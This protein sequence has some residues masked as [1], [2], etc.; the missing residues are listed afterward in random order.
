MQALEQCRVQLL[1]QVADLAADGG[2]T[3]VQFFRGTTETAVTAGRFERHQCVDR[4]QPAVELSYDVK[5]SQAQGYV[6]FTD[7]PCRDHDG[8]STDDG[9][10][11]H[12]GNRRDPIHAGD[13][14]CLDIDVVGAYGY[15]TDFSRTFLAGDGEVSAHQRE[16]YRLAHEE[17][18]YNTGLIRPGI[19]FRQLADSAW[20]IPDRYYP[21]CYFVMMHGCGMTGEYPYTLHARDFDGAYDGVVEENMALCVESCIGEPNGREGMKLENEYLVTADGVENLTP[22]PVDNRP[23]GAAEQAPPGTVAPAVPGRE[24]TEEEPWQR[25]GGRSSIGSRRC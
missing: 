2:L 24:T 7:C 9:Q 21:Q 23:L 25:P 19:T 5:L 22:Y 12:D 1:F 11:P 18:Q 13:L 10:A 8:S 14:V 3:D 4:G 16:L 15:Y 20:R 6:P 17:V